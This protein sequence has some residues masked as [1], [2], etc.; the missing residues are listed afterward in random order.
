MVNNNV[1]NSDRMKSA[2]CYVPL[3]GAII[4]FMEKNKSVYLV[5]HIKYGTFLFVAYLLIRIVLLGL[6]LPIGGILLIAYLGLAIYLGM[7]AYNGENIDI[8]AIDSFYDNNF[9]GNKNPSNTDKQEQTTKEDEFKEYEGETVIKTNNIVVD[10]IANGVNKIVGDV[11]KDT[12]DEFYEGD[13]STE[14][15]VTQENKE[16]QKNEDILDF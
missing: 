1:S 9:K 10:K 7:K 13:D 2:L 6:Y 5:K 15:E 4:H 16:K 14:P 12:I 11:K 8:E 3:G